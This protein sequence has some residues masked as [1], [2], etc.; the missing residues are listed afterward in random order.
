MAAER[1]LELQEPA[2]DASLVPKIFLIPGIL[3]LHKSLDLIGSLTQ[4]GL[5]SD[6]LVR[7][8]IL[9]LVLVQFGSN[10]F[11]S[12]L[13]LVQQIILVLV[14]QFSL[15]SFS[16]TRRLVLN[17]IQLQHSLNNCIANSGSSSAIILVQFSNN[18]QDQPSI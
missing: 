9:V 15:F 7:Q 2:T 8:I 17:F 14:L 4:I 1:H 12:I 3:D 10:N 16:S 18:I 6:I 11:S 13:V 5:S